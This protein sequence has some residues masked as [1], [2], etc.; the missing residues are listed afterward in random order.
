MTHKDALHVTKTEIL[1]IT[2]ETAG[3]DVKIVR[4]REKVISG[5][6]RMLCAFLP[7]FPETGVISTAIDQE[8]PRCNFALKKLIHV[9]NTSCTNCLGSFK[10]IVVHRIVMHHMYARALIR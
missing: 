1:K 8:D 2:F 7:S 6:E 3:T 10:F 9:S 5:N 4:F